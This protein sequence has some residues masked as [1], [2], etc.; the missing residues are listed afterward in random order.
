M[1]PKI[2]GLI[3]TSHTLIPVFQELVQTAFAGR[4]YF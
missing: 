1:K 3:H 2:L 4:N